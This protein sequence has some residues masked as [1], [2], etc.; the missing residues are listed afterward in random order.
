MKIDKAVQYVKLERDYL[1]KKNE[2]ES[3]KLRIKIVTALNV[4]LDAMDKRKPKKPKADK[5]MYGVS[6]YC[7]ECNA[8]VSYDTHFGTPRYCRNC[9]QAIDWS[10][11][12]EDENS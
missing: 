8:F 7:T 3:K 11:V 2:P 5:Y 1:A 12:Q 6:Y 10:E 4:A 9:G